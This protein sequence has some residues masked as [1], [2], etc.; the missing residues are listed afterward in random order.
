MKRSGPPLRRVPLRRVGRVGRRR[1]AV[2]A[3]VV[4]EVSERDGGC[5]FEEF[6]LATATDV[7]HDVVF[8]SRHRPP[9][10]CGGRLDRHELIPRSAWPAGELV[11]SNIVVLCRRHHSWVSDNPMLAHVLG[12]HG[13]SW[14]RPS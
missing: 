8:S 4:A 9:K 7:L 10:R 11:A 6:L 5:R 13:F 12:L 1:A 3:R 2:R 14:E